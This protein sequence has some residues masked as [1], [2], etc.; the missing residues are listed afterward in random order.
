M[1]EVT[2]L[3]RT[4]GSFTA[5]DRAYF[6]VNQGSLFCLVGPNG[7]GKSTT[8]SILTTLSPAHSGTVAYSINANL[9]QIGSD[10]AAIRSKI[11]VVFQ[12]SLLDMPLTV[13][14]NLTTR[15]RL[16]GLDSIDDVVSSLHLGEILGRKYGTLSGGQRRRV[17]IAR[18]LLVSPEV[19]FLDE[20]TTGLDPQSRNLVWETIAELRQRVGLTVVLTT[21]YMEEAEQADHVAIMDHGRIIA[22]GSPESLRAEYSQNLVKIRGSQI[23]QVL[24]RDNVSYSRERDLVHI[25]VDSCHEAL[26]LLN[27]YNDLIEDFEVVHGGMDNVFL[28]LTGSKLREG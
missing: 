14:A 28:N 9:Y 17:D 20:P 26:G 4:Y 18:A 13:R 10:D 24:D 25:P 16:Y 8:I 11:G 19:L 27:T 3:T 5:V 6:T 21:H 2:D 1:I 7:A 12:D 15:A 22:E 23:P